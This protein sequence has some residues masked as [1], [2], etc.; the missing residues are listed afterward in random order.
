MQQ[1]VGRN[2]AVA[3]LGAL[4]VVQ[5]H[6]PFRLFNSLFSDHRLLL[7]LVLAFAKNFPG[8]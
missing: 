8:Y 6:L 7:L 1:G 3:R 2:F 5:I 4:K